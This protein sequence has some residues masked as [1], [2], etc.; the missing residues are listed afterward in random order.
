MATLYIEEYQSLHRD[1][2]GAVSPIPGELVTTQ[3]VTISGSTAA[4]SAV[5]QHTRY[6]CLTSDTACQFEVAANPTASG[7]SRYLAANVP[8]FLPIRGAQKIAVIT[9]Q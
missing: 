8:R 1:A 3:K 6:V 5:Q 9:Q 2:Q 4:S 7:T